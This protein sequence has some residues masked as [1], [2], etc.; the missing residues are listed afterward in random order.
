[1][2]SKKIIFLTILF[3][4]MPFIAKAEECRLVN[5]NLNTI[6]SEVACG[7]EHFYIIEN[8]NGNIK[9]L[10]KYNLYVGANYN[11]INL[12]INET[13]YI[14][15]CYDERCSMQI[16]SSNIKYYF[17]GEEVSNETEWVSRI[18]NKYN[19]DDI[20]S[21]YRNAEPG[22]NFAL[23]DYVYGEK[24]SEGGKYYIRMTYKLY[25][26]TYIDDQTA[27]YALQNEIALGVTGEKG[28]ANYPINATLALFPGWNNMGEKENTE[29]YASFEDGYLNFD[30]KADYFVNVYL[31]DYKTNLNNMGYS[32]SNVDM[33]DMQEIKNL[34]HAITNRDL[35][36]KEW[37]DNSFGLDPTLEED[38]NEYVYLGDLK[39]YLSDDYK[40]IWNTTYWTKTFAG[41]GFTDSTSL[42]VYFVSTAGDICYSYSS[43]TGI[44]RAGIRPVV[45]IAMNNV[46][47]PFNITTETEGS[48]SVE[49]VNK[50]MAD[51]Q[52]TFRAIPEKNYKIKY[53]IVTDKL[54]NSVTFKEDQLIQNNDGTISINSFTM[55]SSDVLIKVGFELINPKTGVSNPIW[56]MFIGMI[57]SGLAYYEL[58]RNKQANMEL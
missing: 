53:V 23:Y 35:P 8:N 25:P 51:E 12:D 54:G 2:D 29:N 16:N 24:F 56:I 4:F 11:K 18:E 55:P 50:A 39:Q 20:Q 42:P 37:Y 46:I 38:F 49:V 32:V 26:Y 45:T 36:L 15:E 58:N 5:G 13:Y 48:G 3:L 41:N 31:A 33:I 52:I 28:K 47:D 19:L 7:S 14:S 9:M 34:V 43:C 40:W 17:E 30:F 10:S 6:G 22:G 44:P 57:L 27:G 1:M 21:N